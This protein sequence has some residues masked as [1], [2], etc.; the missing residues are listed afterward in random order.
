MTAPEAAP[1]RAHEDPALFREALAEK[2]RTPGNGPVD[3]SATRLVDLRPQLEAQL[4][5]VL[6]DADFALFD[7]DRAFGTVAEVAEAVGAE[8]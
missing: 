4:K 3:V 1:L 6:R 5:P 2:L 7:L 8:R